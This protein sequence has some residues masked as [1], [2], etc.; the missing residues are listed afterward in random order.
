V[1]PKSLDIASWAIK[2]LRYQE[3]NSND[4]SEF[5]DAF[6][7]AYRVAARQLAEFNANEKTACPKLYGQS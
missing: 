5:F 6:I 1:K 7:R 4:E 2:L 3:F